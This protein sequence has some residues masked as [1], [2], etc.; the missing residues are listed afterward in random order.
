MSKK[1]TIKEFIEQSKDVHGDKYGYSLTEY[2][3]TATKVKLECPEHGVFEVRPNDHLSKGVGCNKCNNA[4]ISKKKNAKDRV[5]TRFIEAHGD[6]YDYSLMD[7]QGADTKTTIICPEHGEFEVTPRH[8]YNGIGCPACVGL[9]PYTTKTFIDKAKEIHGNKYDYN[10]VDYKN[11]ATKVKLICPEHG[12]FQVRPNDHLSKKVGCRLC[13]SYSM[14]DFIE[15]SNKIHDDRYDYSLVK[16]KSNYRK[17]KI[18]CN[19]HGEFEQ[20]LMN[21]L[22]GCGC[23]ICNLSKG[24]LSVKKYLEESNVEYIREKTFDG[25]EDKK[26]LRFDF[27]LPDHNICI[28]YDGIQHYEPS[29]FYGGERG[30]EQTKQRDKIKTQYCED[31]NIRLIR[32]KYDEDVEN[33][34]KQLLVN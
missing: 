9:R 11:T 24:E 30:F 13:L 6:K 27:Y 4:G 33:K 26:H 22:N 29:D 32:I 25:C 3:N 10:L 8:H 23:P 21:H 14:V 2:V 28:E 20:C 16:I 5:L 17:I 12:E 1:K 18:I 31:N 15:K 19:K 34:L 7:Y